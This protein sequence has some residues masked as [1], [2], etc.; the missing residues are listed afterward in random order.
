LLHRRGG[1]GETNDSTRDKK[2]REEGSA[3]SEIQEEITT[4][5]I[6][7]VSILRRADVHKERGVNRWRFQKGKKKSKKTQQTRL[8]AG[9]PPDNLHEGKN[10]GSIKKKTDIHQKN[11]EKES[12]SG[13]KKKGQG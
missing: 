3:G 2:R 11:Q 13:L 12:R 8:F 6:T 7:I 9:K 10:E 4:S 5:K 1:G